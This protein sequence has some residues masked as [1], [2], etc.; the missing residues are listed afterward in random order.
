[1]DVGSSMAGCEP[2][3]LVFTSAD[4]GAEWGMLVFSLLSL[5]FF[6]TVRDW[7]PMDGAMNT[8]AFPPPQLI[9]PGNSRTDSSLMS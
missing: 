8:Q 4:Q 5:L 9:V 6:P 1:M 3:L 7:Q 2:E